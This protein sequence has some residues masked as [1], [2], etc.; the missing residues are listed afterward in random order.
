MV[1]GVQPGNHNRIG[2]AAVVIGAA[3]QDIVKSLL[4]AGGDLHLQLHLFAGLLIDLGFDLNGRGRDEHVLAVQIGVVADGG[5]RR[6]LDRL[7]LDKVPIDRYHRTG[8]NHH[9]GQQ[10]NCAA[11]DAGE[12]VLSRRARY[13]GLRFSS[14]GGADRLRFAAAGG[15]EPAA[16]LTSK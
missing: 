6:L 4:V 13:V 7:G 12:A 8:Q 5:Q 10:Q 3:D 11:L 15:S 14:G 1:I 9:A 16:V 2:A